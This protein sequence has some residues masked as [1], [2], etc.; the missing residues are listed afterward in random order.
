MRI[1]QLAIDK[2]DIT[3]F[4]GGQQS[5]FGHIFRVFEHAM[6]PCGY[7]LIYYFDKDRKMHCI[8]TPLRMK[9]MP[10][11]SVAIL[12]WQ[13]EDQKETDKQSLETDGMNH[14]FWYQLNAECG[15]GGPTRWEGTM[16]EHLDEDGA[17]HYGN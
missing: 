6:E 13:E 4:S 1:I 11:F 9:Y 15:I 5:L 3:R 14:P 10:D 7:L 12:Q 16:F 8:E 2:M 17:F